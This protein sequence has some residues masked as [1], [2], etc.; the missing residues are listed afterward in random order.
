MP[1]SH[2]WKLFLSLC[3]DSVVTTSLT[4]LSPLSHSFPEAVRNSTPTAAPGQRRGLAQDGA[5]QQPSEQQAAAEPAAAAG[6]EGARRRGRR[7]RAGPQL[8]RG[9]RGAVLQQPQQQ[10]ATAE[11]RHGRGQGAAAALHEEVPATAGESLWHT[12]IV[13]L[14]RKREP[15]CVPFV[16][17]PVKLL[18]GRPLTFVGV[19]NVLSVKLRVTAQACCCE[20]VFLLH[21]CISNVLAD[22]E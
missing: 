10:P 12:G 11:Q 14:S 22:A 5:A 1:L 2:G 15:N 6:D 20:V 9:R 18:S 3:C 16:F 8:D 17:I 13:V 7:R 21:V 4:S 19:E